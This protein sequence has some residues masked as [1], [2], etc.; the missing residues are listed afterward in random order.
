MLPPL[1]P[2]LMPEFGMGFTQAGA[3][4]T[5]FFVASGTGQAL[6]G[7]V[8]DRLGAPRVLFAGIALFGAAAVV[9]GVAQGYPMLLAAAV[10][11]GLGNSVF[12][13][14]DF[15]LLNHRVSPGRLGAAFSVHG[16]SGNLGWAAAP[17]F[18]TGVA[19]SL[20]W[21]T[22]AF[23]AAAVA[24]ASLTVLMLR[25]GALA[26]A[27]P[28]PHHAAGGEDAA[29][30][31]S[32][33]AFLGVRA[34]WM[35][36]LFFLVSTMSF[37][38][39]QNF[40]PTVLQ[41][42]YG[43]SLKAAASALTFYMLGSATGIAVGGWLAAR[44]ETHD[45]VIALALVSAAATALW[46]ASGTAPAGTVAPAMVFI[47]FCTGSANPSRDLLVRRAAMARFGRRSFGRIYGFVYSGLDVGLAV[48]PLLF[49]GLLDRGLFRA[50][51]AGVAGLQ[52]LA[53][54]AAVNVGREAEVAPAPSEA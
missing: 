6:A 46:L 48:A 39:L 34:V 8:V 40:A 11:A 26:D 35:C 2:W 4:M 33:F 27:A 3:L 30:A 43:L 21:R 41:N 1:F 9:L 50:V 14:V 54:L 12:H 36:F 16:L 23:C 18:M 22:A 31:A 19:A 37:G 51:L 38:A 49:G 13:P 20:G 52:I 53:V 47:G 44:S 17:L 7:F 24:L 28:G 10:L 42:A 5:A 32:P 45:R 15:T 29:P 25:R